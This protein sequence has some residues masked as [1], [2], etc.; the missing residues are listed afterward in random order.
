MEQEIKFESMNKEEKKIEPV[1]EIKIERRKLRHKSFWIN[2]TLL[3][4]FAAINEKYG[5]SFNYIY[6]ALGLVLI[7]YIRIWKRGYFFE[8]K[9]GNKLNFKQ[10]MKRFKQGVEGITPLQQTTTSLLGTFIALSGE[11]FGIVVISISKMW[12]LL[13]VIIGG[14]ICTLVGLISLIQ[15][16]LRFKEMDKLLKE[17]QCN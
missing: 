12:W 7:N 4:I 8:D 2:F 3:I 10:F 5:E 14:T 1:K 13:L 16:Y 17:A 11:V 9:K 15:K 6:F